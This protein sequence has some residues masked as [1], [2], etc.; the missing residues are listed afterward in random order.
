MTSSPNARRRIDVDEL[1]RRRGQR[2]R[3][4]DL[5][6]R[7]RQRHEVSV[8]EPDQQLRAAQAR[9]RVAVDREPLGH[10]ALVLPAPLAGRRL[11]RDDAIGGAADVDQIG[12]DLGRALDGALAPVR[13]ANLAGCR[14][15]RRRSCR[16]RRRGR[17]ARA[18]HRS[19]PR[20]RCRPD[21][22]VTQSRWPVSGATPTTEPARDPITRR[23]C[24]P[25]TPDAHSSGDGSKRP[26][27]CSVVRQA[28]CRM[29]A[30][31]G[32]ARRRRPRR[33]RW[34]GAPAAAA[35]ARRQRRD[36]RE[37]DA[38]GSLQLEQREAVRESRRA[39]RWSG[40]CPAP[41]DRSACASAGLPC[42]SARRAS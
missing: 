28:I 5:A 22:P 23:P 33:R 15:R 14:D 12:A 37:T 29:P 42:S 13:P 24:R 30:R 35:K 27:S 3:P 18:R 39:T 11:Q 40:S 6:A 8:G 38:A 17:P 2:L 19:G 21:T 34:R 10:V 4:G 16:R 32:G 7:R 41:R 26:W 25:A 9:P 20:C 36:G 1:V 31:C